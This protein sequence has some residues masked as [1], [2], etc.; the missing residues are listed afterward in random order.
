MLLDATNLNLK[1]FKLLLD[2]HTLLQLG[3][4][5]VK[6]TFQVSDLFSSFP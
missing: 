6:Y 1:K 2:V 3:F 4:C 5:K